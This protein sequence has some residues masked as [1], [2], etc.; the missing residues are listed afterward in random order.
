M[1]SSAIWGN[2]GTGYTSS[3]YPDP[4]FPKCGFPQKTWDLVL[5]AIGCELIMFSPPNLLAAI[6]MMSPNDSHL[7][8]VND[9]GREVLAIVVT[10]FKVSQDLIHYCRSKRPA[11]TRIVHCLVERVYLHRRQ[12]SPFLGLGNGSNFNMKISGHLVTFVLISLVVAQAPIEGSTTVTTAAGITKTE[13]PV[14]VTTTLPASS[15]S[16]ATNK[17]IAVSVS[18]D[19]GM[20]K[21]DRSRKS[22]S[23][24]EMV[25]D[26]MV[27]TSL[28]A[29]VCRGQTETGESSAMF[30]LEPG[31][32][33]SN[34]IIGPDQAEGVHCK[35]VW[36]ADNARRGRSTTWPTD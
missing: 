18:F 34:V 14:V 27:L 22:H 7:S 4:C 3:S 36:Y 1:A 23:L 24:R 25:Q 26:V 8:Q 21:Y 28:P 2:V 6:Y 33:L 10:I 5:P 30:I 20:K 29:N 15:G 35:G 11:I 16:V 13:V 32:T 19:G 31:A 12:P 17:A 9:L